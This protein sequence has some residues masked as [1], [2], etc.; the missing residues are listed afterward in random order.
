MSHQAKGFVAIAAALLG[1][2]GALAASSNVYAQGA[3]GAALTDW[4]PAGGTA[5]YFADLIGVSNIDVALASDGTVTLRSPGFASESWTGVF[6][7]SPN[8]L[9]INSGVLQGANPFYVDMVFSNPVCSEGG[10]TVTGADKIEYSFKFVGQP[11][12]LDTASGVLIRQ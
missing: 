4:I 5:D 2:A 1:F 3:C 10:T 7:L 9:T 8:G 11:D 6:H 12:S